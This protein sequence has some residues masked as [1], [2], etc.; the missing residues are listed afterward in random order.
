MILLKNYILQ[1][2]DPRQSGETNGKTWHSQTFVFQEIIPEDA[3]RDT[4]HSLA[5]DVQD[6]PLMDWCV[7]NIGATVNVKVRHFVQEYKG[8]HF[9]RLVTR[10]IYVGGVKVGVSADTPTATAPAE[11][12]PQGG[13]V[14]A[15]D[16]KN[17]LP[18]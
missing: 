4:P 7:K 6:L 12:Q 18:F 16:V 2:A 10:S 11:Q 9:N 14:Y 8:R 15:K 17:D 13:V 3:D 1:S 5:V